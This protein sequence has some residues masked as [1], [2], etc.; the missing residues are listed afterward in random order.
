MMAAG[1][2][3]F[4]EHSLK[5]AKDFLHTV[6]VVDDEAEYRDST[7]DDPTTILQTPG[8]SDT[9]SDD[10]EV[11]P[12]HRHPLNAKQLI[13]TFA[14]LGM[15]CAI[16]KP[17][18]DEDFIEKTDHAS[19][20]ADIVVLDWRIGDDYGTTTTQTIEKIIQTDNGRLRLIVVYSGENLD[21]IFDRLENIE[22]SA[23]KERERKKITFGNIQLI[24]LAKELTEQNDF[25]DQT[26]NE[27]E[28]PTRITV[29]FRDFTMGLLANATLKSI[30]L[31]RANAHTL[32]THFRPDLDAAFLTHRALT[33]PPDE[34]EEHIAPLL[35]DEM[36]SIL[37]SESLG[38]EVS[39]S[40]IEKW[41]KSESKQYIQFRRRLKVQ[42][43]ESDTID[44][45]IELLT[46]GHESRYNTLNLNTQRPKGNWE[47]LI[48]KIKDPQKI[49][50]LTELWKNTDEHDSKI[51]KALA[52]QMISN[53]R[54]INPAPILKL[55]TI[56][57]NKESS[58]YYL[59]VQ[60]L[61][62]CVRV[63][64]PRDFTL[65]QLK[66]PNDNNPPEII[67]KEDEEYILLR[68]NYR[69]HEAEKIRF[70]GNNVTHTVLAVKAENN[71]YIFK[72]HGSNNIEFLFVSEL[73][74]SI[75]QRIL[76]KFGH[77]V[78]RHGLT[79]S[80]W[81]RRSSGG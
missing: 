3:S 16:L 75:A 72:S 28:L 1:G 81:L 47:K 4:E 38:N 20:R 79:E 50:E 59:C 37:D 68:I 18:K 43:S 34:A 53:R 54:Y 27:T 45:L 17:D 67:I 52:Y 46:K 10:S 74:N 58:E 11:L 35:L 33:A 78:S 77:V 69:P 70:K 62:D 22:D 14:E 64:N 29:E 56:V 44:K 73:K 6:V 24:L 32:L 7:T 15:V 40:I 13:D 48:K 30:S 71:D 61:C 66:L 21:G 12:V 60:P 25:P 42:N 80:E 39:T 65:I 63:K 23:K 9:T 19:Q 36:H 2:I 76:T 41:L 26:C 55:G 31:I 57:K 51:D 8:K 49:Y 5:I